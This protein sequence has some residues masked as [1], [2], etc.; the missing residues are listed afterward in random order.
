MAIAA[1]DRARPPRSSGRPSPTRSRA[2]SR[3]SASCPARS[4]PT[5]RCTTSRATPRSGSATCVLLQGKTQTNVPEIKAG[6]LGAVAKLKETQTSDLLA[7]KG[8]AARGGADEVPRTGPLVRHRAEDARRRRQDQHV[9]A[10]A[11]GG[12]PEHQLHARRADQRTAA[13]RP[14]SVAHRGD[15]GEAETAVRGRGQPEAAAHPL[16]RDDHRLGRSARPAQE[17]DRRARAVRRLQDQVRAAV[18]RQRLRVRRRHLRRLDPAPVHPGGRKGPAGRPPARLPG[19]LPDG[20]LQGDG[21]RRLVPPGRLERTVVQDGRRRSP[22]RTA[23]RGRGR[24][25]SSR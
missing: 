2:A 3:C 20:R 10:P 16:S 21:V 6:D 23:W 12:G 14:G 19:R 5:R 11:P 9:A 7:D 8:V 24:P 15:G 22:S 18:A 17:A 13:G 25:C 1:V 4:S